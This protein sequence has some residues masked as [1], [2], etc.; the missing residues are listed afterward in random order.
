MLL[1]ENSQAI[2][3]SINC[4]V[5]GYIDG[6]VKM[7]IL[8]RGF[9]SVVGLWSLLGDYI[10]AK[11]NLSDTA[12]SILEHHTGT[13]NAH[14]EQL[15]VFGNPDRDPGG[16]VITIVYLALIRADE[17]DENYL[18][19]NK[20]VWSDLSN[21]SELVFD[22]GEMVKLAQKWLYENAKFKPLIFEILPE[23]FILPD[24][25]TIYESI[26]QK[27]LDTRNFRKKILDSGLLIKLEE[28]NKTTSRRGAHYFKFDKKKYY[29]SNAFDFN[30]SKYL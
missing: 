3:I 9:G 11:E 22:H 30:L 2:K 8:D 19:K 5:F 26:Y 18:H 29:E 24:V 10:K 1:R 14:V 27:K 15:G 17:L 28:K 21:S 13:T 6:K 20:A 7:L 4:V 12:F 23:K 16:R 25:Q